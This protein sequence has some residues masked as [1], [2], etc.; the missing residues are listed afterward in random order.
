MG[1]AQDWI[2]V[3]SWGLFWGAA[4]AL[5]SGPR[6]GP[7]GSRTGWSWA[8]FVIWPLAG[9]ACGIGTTFRWRALHGPLLFLMLAA[10]AAGTLTAKLAPLR[11][12]PVDKS[13]YRQ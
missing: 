13:P 8:D 4:M 2:E 7:D 6:I 12:P 3:A 11:P 1:S 9:L 5:M 10:F